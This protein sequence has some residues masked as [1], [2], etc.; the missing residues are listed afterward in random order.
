MRPSRPGLR[1]AS[2]VS[3]LCFISPSPYSSFLP[4]LLLLGAYR[5][6]FIYRALSCAWT[7]ESRK[8]QL[9]HSGNPVSSFFPFL[10][11]ESLAGVGT[12]AKRGLT[13]AD[14]RPFSSFSSS[15]CRKPQRWT[16]ERTIS[17]HLNIIHRLCR[18]LAISRAPVSFYDSISLYLVEGRSHGAFFY[19][20]AAQVHSSSAAI[21]LLVYLFP[22]AVTATVGRCTP[23]AGWL[24]GRVSVSLPRRFLLSSC[25]SSSLVPPSVSF[26][27]FRSMTSIWNCR[28]WLLSRSS[29][30]VKPNR[31]SLLPCSHIRS[32]IYM[33]TYMQSTHFEL[34]VIL[35]EVDWM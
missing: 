33:Y 34:S 4:F 35:T 28:R 23:C 9:L 14:A 32:G 24:W 1:A 2:E 7:D 12:V 17:S 21:L 11:D 30:I 22:V 8:D 26:A 16:I 20:G 5:L 29:I 6:L 25:L 18:P 13:V 10:T 3:P 27:G 19:E 15:S 31:L